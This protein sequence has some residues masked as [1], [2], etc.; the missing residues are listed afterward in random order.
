LPYTG[1]ALNS[2]WK[3]LELKVLEIQRTRHTQTI[4]WLGK[5]KLVTLI[6]NKFPP[7]QADSLFFFSPPILWFCSSGNHPLIN[8]AKFDDTQ[9]MKAENHKHPLYAIVTTFVNFKI[10][11]LMIFLLKKTREIVTEYSSFKKYFWQNGE[12]SP[13]QKSQYMYIFTAF[14]YILN[15]YCGDILF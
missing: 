14:K 8:L 10:D 4:D 13:P 7:S 2:L 12:N 6:T 15:Q 11:F 3:W 5:K 9:N 1:L